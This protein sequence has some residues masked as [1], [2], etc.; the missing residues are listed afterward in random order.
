MNPFNV[1][2]LGVVVIGLVGA[3]IARLR[4]SGMALAL[5]GMAVAQVLVPFL[6]LVFWKTRLA[7]GGPSSG[8]GLNG[9]FIV[10]FVMSASLLRR[11]A[12]AH[13]MPPT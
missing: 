3:A 5:V 13:E 7:P 1:M 9:V 8:F 11:A 4:A 10:L 12:R 2:Y 6:A